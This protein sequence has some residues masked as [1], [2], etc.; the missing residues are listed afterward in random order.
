MKSKQLIM[1]YLRAAGSVMEKP[2]EVV[3][4]VEHLHVLTPRFS[5]P[6]SS[7]ASGDAIAVGW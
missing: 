7:F 4:G 5:P 2:E 6:P 3:V 1:S